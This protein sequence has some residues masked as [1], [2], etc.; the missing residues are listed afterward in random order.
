MFNLKKVCLG[1]GVGRGLDD[2]FHTEVYG[3][4]GGVSGPGEPLFA[5]PL[6]LPRCTLPFSGPLKKVWFEEK[7]FYLKK[8]SSPGER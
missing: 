8:H 4:Q 1:N 5:P 6:A 2:S 3:L 7:V